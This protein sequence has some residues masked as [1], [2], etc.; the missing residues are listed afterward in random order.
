MYFK[1][2]GCFKSSFDILAMSLAVDKCPSAG[3]PL[4]FLNVVLVIPSSSALLFIIPTKSFSVPPR[5]SAK[6][7]AA[8][9]PDAIATPF[10]SSSTVLIS[11]VS[12]SI[13]LPPIFLAFSLHVTLSSKAIFPLSTASI[14]RSIVIILVTDAGANFSSAFFS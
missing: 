12:R 5:Y 10:K 13:V 4:Q 3:R 6:A 2:V 11:P 8:S 7:T 1:I 9:F 14:V